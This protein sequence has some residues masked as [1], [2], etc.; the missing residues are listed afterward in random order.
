MFEKIVG[1]FTA[2]K[3]HFRG[4]TVLNS[5]TMAPALEQIQNSLLEADVDYDVC[6][7][8]L[9]A[10]E[11]QCTGEKIRLKAGKGAQRKQITPSDYFV[12]VCYEE[13]K[14]IFGS[15]PY[16]FELSSTLNTVMLVGLQ[17]V[18]KT[19][20]AGKLAKLLEAKKPLLVACDIYRPAAVEQLRVVAEATGTEFFFAEDSSPSQICEQAKQHAMMGGYEVMIIDTAGRLSIDEDL[21]AE[22]SG[23]KQLMTPNH[24]FLVVDAMM[25]QDAVKTAVNFQ[26]SVDFDAVIMTKIDGDARGGA[27]LSMTQITGKSIAF[28]G[29]GEGYEDLEKFHPEGFSTR[30]LGLGDVVSL[31]DDFKKIEAEA[32]DFHTLTGSQNLNYNQLV[33]VI[34]TFR[35]LGPLTNI[36]SKL[37]TNISQLIPK[38]SEQ[39]LDQLLVIVNSMTEGE[40]MLYDTFTPSRIKRIAMGSGT[41]KSQV[42]LLVTRFETIFAQMHNDSLKKFG[43]PQVPEGS[44][45]SPHLFG[46]RSPEAS[47]PQ[48]PA[49]KK[50]EANLR[51]KNK[52]K[53]KASRKNR[54]K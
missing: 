17:G 54:R 5:A 21:M 1:G 10:V 50:S 39:H 7:S 19:T 9:A 51:K 28:I 45:F 6:Q 8:F 20:T 27:A 32:D 44:L 24:T 35:K 53:R 26:K 34:K 22:I 13:L 49:Q 43:G 30:V 46:L 38:G 47:T 2:A 33:K 4:R 40:R 29:R 36:I 12:S 3:D 37:P 16:T 18:G 23:L 15:N 25:G 11:K 48:V 14:K 52:Q 41:P 42:H 31:M